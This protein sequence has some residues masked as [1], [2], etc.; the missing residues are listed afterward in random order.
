MESS[1]SRG[2]DSILSRVALNDNKAGMQGLD[3]DKINKIILET[4]KV[5]CTFILYMNSIGLWPDIGSILVYSVPNT[6]SVHPT[7][8]CNSTIC[9]Q[10]NG[11][12]V[13][14]SWSSCPSNTDM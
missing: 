10:L 5:C 6:I 2:Q 11:T 8:R 9:Q 4:S 3:K 7:G 12:N 14:F 13:V 1:G